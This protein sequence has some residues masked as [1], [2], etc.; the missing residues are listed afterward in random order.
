MSISTN[1]S[2]VVEEIRAAALAA[3]RDPAEITLVAATKTQ[4][5]DTIRQAIAAGVAVCGEN[6]V[7]ELTAHWEAGAY[8]GARVHFIGHLQTNKVKYLVGKVDLIH[9][10]SSQKLLLEIDRQAAKAGLVQEV[11]LEV[12]L[13]QEPSKSGFLC[14]QVL[15]A[16]RLAAGLD[17]VR[18]RGL[19]CI[20]PAATF[21]EENLPFFHKLK[22]LAVDIKEE[23]GDNKTDMTILSMGMSRDFTAAIAAGATHVRVGTAIF[24]PRSPIPP[25]P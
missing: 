14:S 11:L 10:V 6:R 21:P 2:H 3:G 25:S 20:P 18:V 15:P 22:A 23:M 5:D 24:G 4:S 17:H 12:N 16:A 7:Q 13:A 1:L 8:E 9:S 19:M